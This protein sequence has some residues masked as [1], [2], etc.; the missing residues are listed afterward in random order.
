MVTESKRSVHQFQIRNKR[1]SFF[2]MWIYNLFCFH[3]PEPVQTFVSHG[4]YLSAVAYH[5][6]ERLIYRFP[7]S[8]SNSSMV[9]E[10]S[11][12]KWV[13]NY[14]F[15]NKKLK[16]RLE[17]WVIVE[18]FQKVGWRIII[19]ITLWLCEPYVADALR[20]VTEEGIKLRRSMLCSRSICLASRL[21]LR[22]FINACSVQKKNC[23]ESKRGNI[24][25]SCHVYHL[26]TQR[27]LLLC[28]SW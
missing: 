20:Y 5:S 12:W 23:Q 16:Q 14:P 15:Q 3:L 4:F 22:Y 26:I 8:Y 7:L 28:D 24:V 25:S 11:V 19:E 1:M 21:L 2:H 17:Q 9:F 27:S 18:I 6:R 13:K 10:I